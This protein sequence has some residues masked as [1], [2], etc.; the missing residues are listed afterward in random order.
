MT[1]PLR[2]QITT[3]A[4]R[5]PVWFIALRRPRRFSAWFAGRTYPPKYAPSTSATF[6]APPIF[7]SLNSADMASRSLCSMTQQ[8]LCEASRSGDV[9]IG[10]EPS[11]LWANRLALDIC[12]ADFAERGLGFHFRR[13]EHFREA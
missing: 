5:L 9:L 11:A 10:V 13:A 2:S 4:C 7:R 12:P 6:S 1:L 3:S 8:A